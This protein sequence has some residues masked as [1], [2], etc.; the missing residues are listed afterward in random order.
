MGEF[1]TGSSKGEL[2]AGGLEIGGPE[3]EGLLSG[4]FDVGDLGPGKSEAGAWPEF[5]CEGKFGVGF[6]ES[7]LVVTVDGGF[8]VSVAGGIVGV[9]CC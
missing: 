5:D 4:D 9:P 2:A 7:C 6:G 3:A 1:D 8:G